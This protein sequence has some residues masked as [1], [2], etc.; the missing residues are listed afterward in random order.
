METTDFETAASSLR[1]KLVDIGCFYLSDREE[2]EDVA[3]ETMLKLW[4]LRDR[5]DPQ[6]GLEPLAATIARNL[7]ISRLRHFKSR[8]HESFPEHEIADDMQNAQARM[9][10]AENADW[11]RT[12]LR[13][14]P[15]RYR[16]VLRMRQAEGLDTPEIA[17]LIGTSENAVRILLS[18]ARQQMMKLLSQRKD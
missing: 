7:C 8:P 11:M 15:D 6:K 13:R 17:R 14:L 10:E 1:A 4:I 2:A 18:R 3:Q 12:A 16:A 9:E 5:I